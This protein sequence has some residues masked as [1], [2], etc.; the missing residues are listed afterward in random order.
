MSQERGTSCFFSQ[1]PLH[2]ISLI[3][4]SG[5]IG[6]AWSRFGTGE[7]VFV[8]LS[9][10]TWFL[11]AWVIPILHQSLVWVPWRLKLRHSAITRISGHKGFELY[12]ALF[13]ILGICRVLALL[14]LGISDRGSLGLHFGITAAILVLATPPAIFT[15]HSV[16]KYFG[17]RRA[18]GIDH[19]DASYRTLPLVK[20]G[21]FK[22]SSNSMYTYGFFLLWVIAAACDSLM[23]VVLAFFNHAYVWIHYYCTEKP[24]MRL[25]YGNQRPTG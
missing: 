11:L 4:L 14:G 16:A 20:E 24:D 23:A 18:I 15:F 6:L 13:A 12:A 7:T 2:P 3:V 9:T 5:I 1:Q 25:I 8:G 17:F 10:R 19:F 21:I 22:Y